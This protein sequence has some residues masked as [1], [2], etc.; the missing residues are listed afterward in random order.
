MFFRTPFEHLAAQLRAVAD[1]NRLHIMNLLL[2]R[3]EQTAA[4]LGRELK[5]CQP[6]LSHHM[7][8]LCATGLV[9]CRKEGVRCF[10]RVNSDAL[11]LMGQRAGALAD[12]SEAVLLAQSRGEP[13]PPPPEPM[14]PGLCANESK[15]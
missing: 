1:P 3:G 13:L 9:A 15:R 7:K 11:R 4:Q 8:T 6:T 12:H 2:L 14:P 5:I 10:Y